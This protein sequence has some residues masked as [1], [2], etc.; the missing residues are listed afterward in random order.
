MQETLHSQE[1][2]SPSDIDGNPIDEMDLSTDMVEATAHI[3]ATEPPVSAPLE[4]FAP[5]ASNVVS[6]PTPEIQATAI[7][8]EEPALDSMVDV[9]CPTQSQPP[10]SHPP[11]S[12]EQPSIMHI[13][14]P[15]FPPSTPLELAAR[16]N[17]GEIASGQARPTFQ[18]DR[19][20]T[21]L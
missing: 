9:A 17:D 10:Q 6:T 11:Q 5:P 19:K 3:M 1:G 2:T 15:Q 4:L 14:F 21:R 16:S 18:E 12:S 8:Q 13:H 20:S 7:S